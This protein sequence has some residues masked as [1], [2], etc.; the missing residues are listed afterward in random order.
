MHPNE[1]VSIM[2]AK[3]SEKLQYEKKILSLL[4]RRIKQ[5]RILKIQIE[6]NIG[7]R[8]LVINKYQTRLR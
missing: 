1:R 5:F 6:K 8:L 2:L 4:T 3:Q 7:V